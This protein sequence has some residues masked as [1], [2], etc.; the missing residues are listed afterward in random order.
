VLRPAGRAKGR[1]VG[2]HGSATAEPAAPLDGLG[3]GSREVEL[4]GHGAE[5]FGKGTHLVAQVAL[6]GS[7]LGDCGPQ[8][9]AVVLDHG[10]RL[11]RRLGE[12]ADLRFRIV[13]RQLRRSR[14]RPA[15]RCS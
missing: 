1:A 15:R 7:E 4:V 13:R 11:G 9:G 8:L 3:V 12:G 14:C 10:D 6:Q 2:Q 5:L